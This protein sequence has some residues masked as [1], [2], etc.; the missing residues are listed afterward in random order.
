M[1]W[2]RRIAS[3][4][5]WSINVVE[6]NQRGIYPSTVSA[7]EDF[8]FRIYFLLFKQFF[9]RIISHHHLRADSCGILIPRIVCPDS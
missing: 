2:G 5:G 8:N 3:R 7:P 4:R 9:H 1:D 6:E